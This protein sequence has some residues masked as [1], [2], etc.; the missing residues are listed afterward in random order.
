MDYRYLLALVFVVGCGSSD[1]DTD[2]QAGTST[3]TE[4][5]SGSTDAPATE[6]SGPPPGATSTSGGETDAAAS[7]GDPVYEDPD[8]DEIVALC[9]SYCGQIEVDGAAC[10]CLEWCQ[11][12]ASQYFVGTFADY[13]ACQ[14]EFA[15][16]DACACAEATV[17]CPT[18]DECVDEETCG[19]VTCWGG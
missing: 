6:S 19:T 9:E 8:S 13:V 14:M 3:Q 10:G 2:T 5:S 4:G 12:L 1:G 18:H 17:D 7:H 16:T 15:T 11:G